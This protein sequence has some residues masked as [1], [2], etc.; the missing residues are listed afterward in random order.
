[1]I[2][3]RSGRSVWRW[4]GW[5]AVA[6]AWWTLDG[7]TDVMNYRVIMPVGGPEMSRIWRTYMWSAW[8]WIPLTLFALWLASRYPFSPGRWRRPLVIHS[9]GA[10]VA[11]LVR[12][13]MVMALNGSIGW[14]AKLPPISE[15]LTTSLA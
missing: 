11:C 7:F 1:M 14:Y 6:T 5:T 2:P 15:L 9:I 13:A 12:A 8:L 4:M 3:R 10:V